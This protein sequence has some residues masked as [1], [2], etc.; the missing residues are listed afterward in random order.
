MFMSL[1]IC[2]KDR[3]P[4]L[5]D[6]LKE[7]A[8]ASPPPCEMEI[9]IVDNG[10]R[11]DTPS[12]IADFAAASALK[13]ERVLCQTPGL[14]RARNAGLAVAKGEW[15][16]FTDDDCYGETAFFENFFGFADLA[17]ASDGQ[18]KDIRYGGG[19]VQPYDGQHDPRIAS[20]A[21]EKIKLIAPKT[22]M[23]PGTIQGAN[24]FFHR[25]I[26]ENVGRFN[27]R[28]GSGTPFA[29]EDIEMAARASWA[30][31]LGA[32]VPFFK[33]VHHHKRLIGSVEAQATVEQYDFGKGAYLASL[34]QSGIFDIWRLWEACS[35]LQYMSDPKFRARLVRELEGAANYLKALP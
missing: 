3:A 35:P 25:S 4:Q 20:L 1:I 34:M 13:V 27:E 24:M 16:L 18:A 5:R 33:V 17:A 8:A 23:G 21:V 30:G 14:G 6:C 29:C 7:V 26:F 19:P 15:V 12:V 28:M 10:S 32:Q 22:L 9:V 11:D 2:T 31:Y